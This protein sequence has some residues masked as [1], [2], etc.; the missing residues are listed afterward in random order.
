MTSSFSARVGD[1]DIINRQLFD[2]KML[3]LHVNASN[4]SLLSV[5]QLALVLY[6]RHLEIIRNQYLFCFVQCS[7]CIVI[8]VVKSWTKDKRICLTTPRSNSYFSVYKSSR[9]EYLKG[10]FINS[11]SDA[12]I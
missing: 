7:V 11:R 8:S 12:I 2:R 3:E 9:S 10:D 6:V 5:K 1:V 4:S